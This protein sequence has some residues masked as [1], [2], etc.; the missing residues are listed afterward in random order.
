MPTP[1]EKLKD[2]QA[3]VTAKIHWDTPDYEVVEWLEEKHGLAEEQIDEMLRIA[4]KKRRLA[5][6]ERALYLMIGA[7]IGI[8]I[9][10]TS[11]WIESYS[12]TAILHLRSI[13]R[14]LLGVSIVAFL[15]GLRRFISGK[16]D[17][18]IDP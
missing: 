9:C 4:H 8:A 6:R 12:D 10:G 18:T 14:I 11:I 3:Q 15:R 7:S 5:I 16:T 13:S 2:L 17:S 1:A